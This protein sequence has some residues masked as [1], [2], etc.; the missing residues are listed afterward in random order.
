MA[1]TLSAQRCYLLLVRH[2]SRDTRQLCAE[3]EQRMEGW[4]ADL[5]VALPDFKLKGLPRTLAIADRLAEELGD[6]TVTQIRHSPHRVASQTA[7]A[8]GMVFAKR[9]RADCPGEADPLLDPDHGSAPALAKTLRELAAADKFKPGT[10]VVVV[11]HQPMLTA[12]ARDLA[13]ELPAGTLPLGGSEAACFELAGD[14]CATLL[15]M[16]TE[17]DD[18]L[19]A[20]LKDKVKS[21]Y[22]VAKF[23]LGAF[24]VN[25]GFLLSGQIWQVES[26][27]A[28]G[29]VALGFILVLVGLALTAATLMSYDRLLMPTE[30]W[31]GAGGKPAGEGQV[32]RPRRW[33]VL[34]PPSQAQVLLFYEMVHVWNVFFL[35]ALGCAFAAL[36]AFLVALFYDNLLR[37]AAAGLPWFLTAGLAAL[38]AGSAL[39]IPLVAHYRPH[40]PE[41]GFDD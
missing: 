14:G 9:E 21:K 38:L 19:M 33:T 1:T 31:T 4:Q 40:R 17:K 16:L 8:F 24:V 28:K 7:A 35:P 2:A 27:A 34:R 41:L 30:F 15:W 29:C 10:A 11:G 39:A 18:K 36:A 13:P 5:G 20:E 22:D 25:T 23:F 26:L 6:V 32:P 37:D 3:R 12:I